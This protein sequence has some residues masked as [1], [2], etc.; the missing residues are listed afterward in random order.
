MANRVAGVPSERMVTGKKSRLLL[1]GM[2]AVYRD[3]ATAAQH[4][5][6]PDGASALSRLTFI[7]R[8][9][10]FCRSMDRNPISPGRYTGEKARTVIQDGLGLTGRRGSGL[11]EKRRGKPPHA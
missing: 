10:D 5:H 8:T 9:V 1:P 3:H 4:A 11:S 2:V 7:G 6:V